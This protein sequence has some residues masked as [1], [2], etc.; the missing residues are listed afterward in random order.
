MI[1]LGL[2]LFIIGIG[3]IAIGFLPI[4]PILSLFFGAI[5]GVFVGN[6]LGAI[7]GEIFI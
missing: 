5:G 4:H 3:F 1:S 6:G 7:I 2:T